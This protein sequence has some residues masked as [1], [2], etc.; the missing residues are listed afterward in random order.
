MRGGWKGTVLDGGW[1]PERY[2]A[3]WLPVVR[4]PGDGFEI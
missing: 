2:C 1:V 4:W 3:W